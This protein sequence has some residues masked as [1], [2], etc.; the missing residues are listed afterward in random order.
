MRQTASPRSPGQPDRIDPGAAHSRLRVCLVTPRFP[1][2]YSGAALRFK[3]YAPGLKERGIELEVVA[4][5]SGHAPEGSDP[6]PTPQRGKRTTGD[7]A[8]D[9]SVH[10]VSVPS[11]TGRWRTQALYERGVLEVCGDP[12]S[13][14]DVVLALTRLSLPSLLVL[15]R[16]AIPVI[17]V[18]T[19]ADRDGK[20]GPKRL[21]RRLARRLH[22]AAI[23]CLVVSSSVMADEAREG[24][25]PDQVRVIPHGVDL[26][27]FQPG[28]GSPAAQE[29]RERL[30]VGD[31]QRLLLFIG[32]L[33]ERKGVDL[34]GAAWRL[35]ADRCP[36]AHMVLVGPA[37]QGRPGQEDRFSRELRQFLGEAPG[38]DRV[39]VTGAVSNVEA[40]YQAADVFVF[41]S[42]REGMPNVVCEAFASGVACLLTP[43]KGLPREFGHPGEQY[44]LVAHQPD[45]LA[46]AIEDLL[47]DDVQRKVISE[48]ARRWAEEEMSIETSL[49]QYAALC[50]EVS[51]ARTGTGRHGG[52]EVSP[53]DPSASRRR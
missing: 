5:G 28:P 45:L 18:Q 50:R 41:P 39:T 29:V 9:P 35:V 8:E 22:H 6:E 43:F 10:R 52:Q 47:N 3:R 32:P 12:A 1:P 40:Y 53:T 37:P 19:M 51:A 46:E 30:G 42:R 25:V 16:W 21:W 11:T 17:Y 33:S 44:R 23:D 24:G 49:D 38:R 7:P 20:V 2:D 34:L 36:D 26:R 13:R 4:L 14:P 48:A 27:K 31:H 15:R